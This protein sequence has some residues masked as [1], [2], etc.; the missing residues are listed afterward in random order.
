MPVTLSPDALDSAALAADSVELLANGAKLGDEWM[1]ML[2]DVQVKDFW[3]QPDM[4]SVRFIDPLGEKVDS[5]PLKL[6]TELVVK[7]GAAKD[8]STT[9]VFQGE[10]V[11]LEPQFR[12]DGVHI[13]VRAFDKGHRFNRIKRSEV[14][15][16]KTA[17]DIV[18]LAIG[19]NGV[20]VGA[21]DATTLVHPHFQQSMETDWELCW[22]LARMNG[23]EF[24]VDD[25]K[26]FFRKRRASGAVTTLT[27]LQ[28]L[29]T[30]TPRVS[31]IGQVS[32]VTVN[33][34]DP[35][36]KAK[37]TGTASSPE[38]QSNAPS[39]VSQ[40]DRV[41]SQFGG[42]EAL[43]AD[44]VATTQG[45]ANTM[46]KGALAR[47]AAAFLEAEGT[48]LGTPKLVAGATVSI[49]GVGQYSGDYVLS[50]THHVFKGG[51]TYT[52]RFEITGD[53]PRTFAQLVGGGAAAGASG[54]G[55]ASGDR[56]AWAS[57]L[58]I[59]LVTNN[60]DPDNMGRVKVKFPTLGDNME[61]EWARVMTLGAGNERGV[62]MMPQIDDT[63]V[64]GFEHGDPRRPF[65]LGTLFTG[66]EKLSSDLK[67]SNRE[68]KF[69]VKTPHQIFAQS[70]KE[71]KLTSNEKM[72]IEIKGGN[73][74][75]LSSTTDG[76]TKLTAKKNIKA[77]ASQ[78]I[79]VSANSSVKIKGNGS[80]EIEASGQLKVKGAAVSIEGSGMV[81]VKGGMIKLG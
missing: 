64:V 66:K 59:A 19:R 69:A 80:V 60:N 18:K 11:A 73:T 52:T 8:K 49:K 6:G 28:N 76:D 20:G 4:A 46:A 35:K 44:R 62:F 50:S 15:L 67:D 21:V 77:E 37:T 3:T 75:E 68:P 26:A 14:Y 24:G 42:G 12:E 29:M 34:Q 51:G 13:A 72:T 70:D 63:V 30:F 23:Y 74:G 61:S 58:M 38:T 57:Q 2:L 65:V 41:I 7:L 56:S 25:G 32:K 31:A 39:I 5:C 48:C 55:G 17:S 78:N 79:E 47:N 10:V 81:E 22:R 36:M 33:S 27:Y 54:G 43:V 40:R 1:R 16:D 45:E 9:K 71:L 53:R